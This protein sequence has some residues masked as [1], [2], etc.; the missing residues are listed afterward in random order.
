VRAFCLGGHSPP[1]S[2]TRRQRQNQ[3]QRP[4]ARRHPNR[5]NSVV[6][7]PAG[8]DGAADRGLR[9]LYW[10]GCM[11]PNAMLEQQQTW[12][13]ILATMLRVCKAHGW[14]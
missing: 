14:N 6:L 9:H 1:Y 3:Q 7:Q 10:H 4:L 13:T 8:S 2:L 5:T 11:F 12:N